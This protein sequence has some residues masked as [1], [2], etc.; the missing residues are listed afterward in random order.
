M[1]TL[2]INNSEL[3]LKK[4]ITTSQYNKLIKIENVDQIFITGTAAFRDA[5]NSDIV[6]EEIREKLD[7]EIQVISGEEEGFLTS[8]GV[9]SSCDIQD[10]FF[11]VDIGGRSTELIYDID[12]RT[13]VNSLDLGV[14]SL[15]ERIL[16]NNP[17]NQKKVS[18]A[19]KLINQNLN[20]EINTDTT[21]LI[22]VAG[23]FTSIASIFLQQKTYNE[24][25]IHMSI[26]SFDWISELSLNLNEM[27]EAQIINKYTSL[28]PKRAKTLSAGVLIITNIMKKFKFDELK[29]SKSDILEGLILKN[30]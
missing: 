7:L 11:I 14:V 5:Q 19:D 3:L 2:K 24:N 18:E 28:D 30:Y 20:I 22:G 13:Q 9:L 29:V 16:K 25:E 8:L 27:T 26:L 15:T 6:I 12:N 23:T 17:L 1:F 10:N 4:T 21:S